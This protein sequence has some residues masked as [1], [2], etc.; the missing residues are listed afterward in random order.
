MPGL[1]AQAADVGKYVMLVAVAITGV[2]TYRIRRYE[3]AGLLTPTRTEGGQ[4]RF[5]D[6]DVAIVKEAARLEKEGI[7]MKGITK[8]LE[9]R[10]RGA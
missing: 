3:A 9:M 2:A 8:I 5:S 7:N 1:E 6:V 10:Q 4:R